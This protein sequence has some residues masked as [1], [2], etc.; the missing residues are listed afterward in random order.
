MVI[1]PGVPVR[2]RSGRPTRGAA[3]D[4]AVNQKLYMVPHRSAL[5]FWFASYVSGLEKETAWPA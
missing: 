2:K 3:A 1:E 5:V 4:I